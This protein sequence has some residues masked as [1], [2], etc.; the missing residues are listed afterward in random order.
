[1]IERLVI[2]C[3]QLYEREFRT[4]R[5]MRAVQVWLR[6]NGIDPSDVPVWSE[7]VI[8]DS[9]FGMVIRYTAY[10]WN[11]DGHRYAD[12]DNPDLVA[13]QDRTAPLVLPPPADWLPTTGGER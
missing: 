4:P 3:H 12:P 8:E 1:M 2:D 11:A 10:R 9:A 7:M 5:G 6:V 13:T